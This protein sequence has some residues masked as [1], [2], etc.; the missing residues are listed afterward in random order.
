MNKE[1]NPTTL[2]KV[3]KNLDKSLKTDLSSFVRNSGERDIVDLIHLHA[4]RGGPLVANEIA[5]SINEKLNHPYLKQIIGLVHPYGTSSKWLQYWLGGVEKSM[6]DSMIAKFRS[7]R[8]NIITNKQLLMQDVGKVEIRM[9]ETLKSM[10]F[11]LLEE[12]GGDFL[13]ITGLTKERIKRELQELFY[14]EYIS[15]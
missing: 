15:F 10:V 7:E 6:A 11:P 2:K 12:Y 14:T 5:L 3:E 1:I 4:C 9:S 8:G 13:R